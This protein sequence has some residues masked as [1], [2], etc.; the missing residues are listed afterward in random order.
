[1]PNY[2]TLKGNSGKKFTLTINKFNKGVMTIFDETRVPDGAVY[3]AQNMYLDQDGVWTTR[4]GSTP[5]GASL[6]TPIDGATS[7]VKYNS[8]GTTNTYIAV[9]DNGAFKY[10]SDGGSWTTVSG[11][12]WTTGKPVCFKQ[13]GSYLWIANGYDK[14]SYY[15]ITAG[16]LNTFTQRSAPTSPSGTATGMSGGT[17]KAYY[18]ITTVTSIGE[19]TGSTEVTVSSVLDRDNWKAGTDYITVSWTGAT[20]A[21]RYNIYYSDT[22]GTE[23]YL[24]SVDSTSTSYIDYGA[25]I[26]NTYAELPTTNT[27]AGPKLGALA[28]SGNRL[29]GT[30]NPDFP[31]RVVWGGTGQYL[32][33]FNP[34][35]GGGYIDLN[36]GSDEKPESVVH[37]R[38][39]KGDAV[40][41]VLTSNP[42]GVGSTWHIELSTLSTDTL[43]IVI[44][45]A[46]SEE[47]A[48]GTR[49]PRGVVEYMN[50][51]HY[52]SPKGFQA[53]GSKQSI[54]NVLVTT[55]ESADIRPSIEGI[56]NQYANLIAGYARYGRIYWAV[57]NSSTTNNEIWVLD[58]ERGG[59]WAL[60]WSLGVK[61][62][63]EYTDSSGVIHFLAVPNTDTNLIEIGTNVSGDSGTAFSTSLQSGL[64]HW[65]ND[66][67]TFA[68]IKRVYI[69][70]A[71][72]TGSISFSVAGTQKG[73]AFS[74]IKS[75]SIS[76]AVSVGDWSSDEWSNFLWGD[77][78][79]NGASFQQ[80]SVKKYVNV[81]KL[82]NNM[83]WQFSST[84]VNSHYTPMQIIIEGRLIP[85]SPPSTW[86]P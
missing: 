32:A 78:G 63:F 69:E 23:V 47:G 57:P 71:D 81:N 51:I 30:K 26:P 76:D 72:P 80:P 4:P 35:D 82:L 19:T 2:P 42:N 36:L 33:S 18:K 61:Q 84:D 27:T 53:L 37:F 70:I 3:Q 38:N 16:T 74:S 44:P 65:D 79:N 68:Y 10:S 66:H 48:V 46:Y 8:D 39:G 9:I 43:Q 62:F 34:F 28:L 59:A 41:T 15:N 7:F 40:A 22:S 49:S 55:D 1:M 75:I 6:T 25:A 56:N 5:Y 83:Q 64:I 60:P 21:T 45:Q 67:A 58:L 20:G 50:A 12:T 52:P 85:T 11:N 86:K 73:K 24:D 77:T 29:W 31:Y 17:K 14:I 13:S 54:L